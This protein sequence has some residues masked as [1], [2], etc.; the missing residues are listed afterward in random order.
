VDLVGVFDAAY[1]LAEAGGRVGV[2]SSLPAVF[3]RLEDLPLNPDED[4]PTITVAGVAY[5]I[6]E[7]QRDGQGGA[8][9]LLHR[10]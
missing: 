4:Q 6:H 7:V 8:L 5:K 10:E 3:V 9:L 1:V 2:T